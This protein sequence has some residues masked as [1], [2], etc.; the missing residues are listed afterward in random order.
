MTTI[1]RTEVIVE[2]PRLRIRLNTQPN[3]S[4]EE[5]HQILGAL[6][7]EVALAYALLS[8]Q[9]VRIPAWSRSSFGPQ[10]REPSVHVYSP[11]GDITITPSFQI[12]SEVRSRYLTVTT[13]TYRNP[14]EIVLGIVGGTPTVCAAI[15]AFIATLNM[16]SANRRKAKA[17]T[18][19]LESQAEKTRAEAGLIRE[20][21]TKQRQDQILESLTLE[22]SLEEKKILLE[23]AKVDLS[24]N[25][26]ELE[27]ARIQTKRLAAEQVED[28]T[29]ARNLVKGPTIATGNPGSWPDRHLGELFHNNRLL[30]SVELMG[31]LSPQIESIDESLL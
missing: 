28:V 7:D 25:E 10:L 26:E 18:S 23:S 22:I 2:R 1:S 29:K 15:A 8:P 31:S 4:T 21:I 9:V 13:L 14:W 11:T 30:A 27:Q 16:L 5:I 12:L 19:L 3:L 6:F 17:E 20:N 24:R